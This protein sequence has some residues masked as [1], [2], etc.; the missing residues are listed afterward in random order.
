MRTKLSCATRV[1]AGEGAAATRPYTYSPANEMTTATHKIA[2]AKLHQRWR[3]NSYSR[4]RLWAG[5]GASSAAGCFALNHSRS[6]T[7]AAAPKIKTKKKT[8]LRTIGPI[9]DISV[10]LEGIHIASLSS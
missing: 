10:L 8:S 1:F 4:M 2:A 3:R 5:L 6:T 7:N 9:V